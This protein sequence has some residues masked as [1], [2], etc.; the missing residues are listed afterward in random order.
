MVVG[1]RVL[2]MIG[3]EGPIAQPAAPFRRI[4]YMTDN[5]KRKARTT[6]TTVPPQKTRTRTAQTGATA[7]VSRRRRRAAAY[8]AA[9]ACAAALAVAAPATGVGADAPVAARV[10]AG[11]TDLAAVQPWRPSDT[12]RDAPVPCRSLLPGQQFLVEARQRPGWDSWPSWRGVFEYPTARQ[13]RQMLNF[14][15][16]ARTECSAG[17]PGETDPYVIKMR[18]SRVAGHPA[19]MVSVRPS[20]NLGGIDYFVVRD[21]RELWF[22]ATRTEFETLRPFERAGLLRELYRLDAHPSHRY[23]R[24]RRAWIRAF[25]LPS[26]TS[27][28]AVLRAAR[29]L[30]RAPGERYAVRVQQLMAFAALP[31]TSLT[32]AEQRRARYLLRELGDFFWTPDP[33]AGTRG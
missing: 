18:R 22:G 24:A 26:A 6:H 11:S 13:A 25:Q 29:R 10:P 31:A 4:P 8:A 2:R 5:T 32:P 17:A 14:F 15:P 28:R 20:D 12:V 16:Q 23:P 33:A 27:D 21:G 7:C 19:R 3:I 1:H 9:L 30:G